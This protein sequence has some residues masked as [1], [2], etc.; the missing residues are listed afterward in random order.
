MAIVVM[1]NGHYFPG[2]ISA[3]TFLQL[4]LDEKPLQPWAIPIHLKLSEHILADGVEKCK[5]IYFY[6]KEN[7]PDQYLFMPWCLTEFKYWLLERNH[8]EEALA[9]EKFSQELKAMNK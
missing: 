4:V 7:N 6:E 3:D 1:T 5:E 9:I 2:W 8:Q